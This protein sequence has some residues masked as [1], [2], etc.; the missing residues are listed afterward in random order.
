MGSTRQDK[1][2]DIIFQIRWH[3]TRRGGA[4]VADIA[5]I[6]GCSWRDADK[7]CHE[8]QT[9]LRFERGMVIKADEAWEWRQ[10]WLPGDDS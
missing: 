5:G 9:N 10:T 7:F 6:L 2:N 4:S 8:H 1:L 3:I